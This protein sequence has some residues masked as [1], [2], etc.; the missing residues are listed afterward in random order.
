MRD[1]ENATFTPLVFM[2][3]GGMAGEATVFYRRL[4]SLLAS[5]RDEPYSVVMGWL[6]CLFSFLLLRASIMCVRGRK[7]RRVDESHSDSPLEVVTSSR[8]PLN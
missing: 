2:S 1:I 3:V 7:K 8:I 5:K 6:R 4:A